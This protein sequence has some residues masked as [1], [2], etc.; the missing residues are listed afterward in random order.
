MSVRLTTVFVALVAALSALRSEAQPAQAAG[1]APPEPALKSA[2]QL[3]PPPASAPRGPAPAAPRPEPSPA[4]A[5]RHPQPK[6][7]AASSD[8]GDLLSVELSMERRGLASV[9][10]LDPQGRAVR[11]LYSGVLEAG[12]RHFKWD[13]KLEDGS[14]PPPGTYTL[15]LKA[16]GAQQRRLVTLR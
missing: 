13:G 11:R 14:A 16:G 4:A 6:S 2:P 1:E 15:L 10:V 7:P 5:P 12:S 9:D 3:V 8:E